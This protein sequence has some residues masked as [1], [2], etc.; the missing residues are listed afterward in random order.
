MKSALYSIAFALL[1]LEYSS[2][3]VGRINSLDSSTSYQTIK[4]QPSEGN[5]SDP[6]PGV[7]NAGSSPHPNLKDAGHL[8]SNISSGR[9]NWLLSKLHAAA[10]WMLRAR[11]AH[12]QASRA[13]LL[14]AGSPHV[15]DGNATSRQQ[16]RRRSLQVNYQAALKELWEDF[17]EEGAAGDEQQVGPH[18]LRPDTH[19]SSLSHA[20][21]GCRNRWAAGGPVQQRA[22]YTAA[23]CHTLQQPKVHCSSLQRTTVAS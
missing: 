13:S 5:V 9:I 10:S 23:V 16:R 20:T 21:A 14:D 18:T 3:V 1:I 2:F 15:S 17:E 22:A 12:Q 6:V 7:V 19:H 4:G 8:S 11:A